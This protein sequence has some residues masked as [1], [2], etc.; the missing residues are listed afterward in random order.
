MKHLAKSP[1]REGGSTR[2]S[3]RPAHAISL[4]WRLFIVFLT[5][6][7]IKAVF[8]AADRR[9]AYFLGDSESY[10]ATATIQWISPA[11]SFLYGLFIRRVSF[12]SHSLE[13]LVFMQALLSGVAAWLLCFALV[14]IFH[15][16]FRVAALFGILCAVEPLQLLME[17][18][19]MTE[20][21]ANCLFAVHF[22][23]ALLYIRKG[24]LWSLLLS[25]VMGVLLIAMRISFL[26]VVLMDSVLSPLLGPQLRSA[27]TSLMSPQKPRW[28]VW[29]EARR[30]IMRRFGQLLLPLALSLLVSQGLMTAYK[31]WYGRL[32]HREPALLYENGAFLISD[33]APLIEEED[34]PRGVPGDKILSYLTIDRHDPANRPGQ[35]FAEGG[36]V[37]AM[38]L[39]FPDP[40]RQNDVETAT[41][42]HALFR[43]PVAAG[44]L[45][46]TT[47]LSYFDRRNLS[48]ALLIDEG[49]GQELMTTARKW[50]EDV[51]NIPEPRAFE[52][53]VTK[54]WHLISIPWYWFI[55]GVLCL[56]PLLLACSERHDRTVIVLCVLAALVFLE[57]ATLTVD[58]V[59]PRFLT[60]DAWLV[61]LISGVTFDR[62]PRRVSILIRTHFGKTRQMT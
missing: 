47:F 22:V 57:G 20:T 21:C 14:E 17:R 49:S 12:H 27:L 5:I 61:L 42:L 15:L 26:P 38:E 40:K 59:T 36:L 3:P 52:P 46:Y 11:R 9:P 32:E 41:A 55:L 51:Y 19:V 16:R 28:Q 23:L 62:L 24:R 56:S 2:N 37:R 35:H 39:T 53:S 48:D 10:L 44:R 30:R 1:Y 6:I 54:T 34:F 25:Q 8:L 13:S 31:H 43:Q 33:F 58:R 45:A 4:N 50:I 29:V 18:Y 7:G 60:T